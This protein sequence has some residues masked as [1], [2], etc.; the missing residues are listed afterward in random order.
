MIE[1]ERTERGRITAEPEVLDALVRAAAA[2]VDGVRLSH[3]RRQVR[4]DAGDEGLTV[5]GSIC[6]GAGTVLPSVGSAVQAR[7]WQALEA[8][9][10]T[11]PARVDVS[12]ESIHVDRTSS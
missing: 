10:G 7:V 8:A 3:R 5:A 12:V 4:I 2:S 11:A 1:L 6:A 9:T